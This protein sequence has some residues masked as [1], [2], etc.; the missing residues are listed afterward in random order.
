[1]RSPTCEVARS[2]NKKMY[3]RGIKL[4]PIFYYQFSKNTLTFSVLVFNSLVGS[5]NHIRLNVIS[6]RWSVCFSSLSEC[7]AIIVTCSVFRCDP[8]VCML[9]SFLGQVMWGLDMVA[10]TMVV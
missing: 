8:D 3:W 4:F 2:V 6:P 1:M 9:R 7:T 10:L 5:G